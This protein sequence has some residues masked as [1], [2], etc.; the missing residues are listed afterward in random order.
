MY[1]IL[2]NCIFMCCLLCVCVCARTCAYLHAV[3][4]EVSSYVLSSH[5]T[6]SLELHHSCV[7]ILI[8]I[9]GCY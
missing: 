1:K 2:Y 8:F 9:M 3:K 4:R 7:F 5:G 6:E